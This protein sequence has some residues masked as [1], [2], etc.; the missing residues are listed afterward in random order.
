MSLFCKLLH[1]LVCENASDILLETDLIIKPCLHTTACGFSPLVKVGWKRDFVH[2]PPYCFRWFQPPRVG[3]SHRSSQPADLAPDV[4][5]RDLAKG[6]RAIGPRDFA[7]A[8]PLPFT[9]QCR[10]PRRHPKVVPAMTSR[11]RIHTP[12]NS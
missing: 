12:R 8:T 11:E 3:K 1:Y 6:Y 2:V 9:L 10:S 5:M 7:G 4:F